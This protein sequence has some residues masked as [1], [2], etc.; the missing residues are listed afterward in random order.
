MAEASGPRQSKNKANGQ[1]T[2]IRFATMQ[3]MEHWVL[4]ITFIVLAVTGLAQKFYT[5]GI[6]EWIVLRLGGIVNTRLIHRIFAGIFTFSVVFHLSY[7]LYGV[8]TK[9]S[10]PSMLPTVK[11][12][13]DVVQDIR[14]SFGLVKKPPQFGRFDYRQK[15]EYWGILFGGFIIILSGLVLWFP[16]VAT[17]FLPGQFV[18]A[19][20]EFHG[21][22][23]TLAVIVIVI[24]HLYD[25]MFR[26]GIFPADTTIFTGKIS[27]HR[28]IEEH[29][30][31]YSDISGKTSE[32]PLEK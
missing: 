8:F 14:Y 29:P 26:P 27:K 21:N 31:E 7:V 16:T 2:F 23:A 22:E 11:D 19:A 9:R 32:T 20:K 28:I 15:F 30:L 1:E 13:R 25:V 6:A 17:S 18:P 3:R 5:G 4:M 12:F 24:W 10:R